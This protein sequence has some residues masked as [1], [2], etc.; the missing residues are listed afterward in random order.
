M[1]DNCL[2]GVQLDAKNSIRQIFNNFALK[3][4]NLFTFTGLS[5]VV[6]AGGQ[7]GFSQNLIINNIVSQLNKMSTKKP[8]KI[9][10]ELTNIF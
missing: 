6:I 7:K 9:S 2:P 1:A 8:D 10:L 3:F 4:Y 5:Q